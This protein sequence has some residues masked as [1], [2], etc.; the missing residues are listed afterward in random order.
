VRRLADHNRASAEQVEVADHLGCSV[1][2]V[3][4][5]WDAIKQT[6]RDALGADVP[7]SG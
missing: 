6:L 3:K 4:R 5:R 1:R 2:T 7:C